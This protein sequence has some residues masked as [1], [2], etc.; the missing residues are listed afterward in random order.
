MNIYKD[1][2]D[3]V[4]PVS[5]YRTPTEDF[6]PDGSFQRHGTVSELE[7]LGLPKLLSFKVKQ[8]EMAIVQ[9]TYD[10]KVSVK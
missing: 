9:R 2:E 3:L 4:T 7:T 1:K 10:Q 5:Q 8:L 6:N